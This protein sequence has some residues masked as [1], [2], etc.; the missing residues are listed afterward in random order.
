MFKKRF[1]F[2][3]LAALLC[4]S[5]PEAQEG[6]DLN[7]STETGRGG[8][9][10]DEKN[11]ITKDSPQEERGNKGGDFD[12]FTE[13][14]R[15]GQAIDEKNSI[16]KDSPR[17]GGSDKGWDFNPSTETGRGGQVTDEKNSITKDS[18]REE[19]SD[20]GWDFNPSTETG[21]GGQTGVN[22]S[23][24]SF[25]LPRHEIG[26]MP[27]QNDSIELGFPRFIIWSLVVF[28]FG[29]VFMG[30]VLWGILGFRKPAVQGSQ[31]VSDDHTSAIK[32]VQKKNVVSHEMVEYM[33]K[34]DKL[35]NELHNL[36]QQYRKVGELKEQ[37]VYL[38]AKL[39]PSPLIETRQTKME[40]PETP[41]KN[42]S[43]AALSQYQNWDSYLGQKPKMDMDSGISG[44][45]SS[46]GLS[47]GNQKPRTEVNISEAPYR[48]Q[49]NSYV[50]QPASVPPAPKTQTAA[51]IINAFN[52]WASGNP[53]INKLP[54]L[55][56]YAN[57][58][59][60]LQSSQTGKIDTNNPEAEW[61]VSREPDTDGRRY[62]FPNP[63]ALNLASRLEELYTKSGAYKAKGENRIKVDSPCIMS[64]KGFISG[65]G[66]FTVV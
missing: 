66:S 59:G 52:T 18:P 50:N 31:R 1:A 53:R 4:V 7:P 24:N 22:G 43:G 23:R 26:T 36:E 44:N 21:R 35:C 16:T 40:T 9:A 15:G 3:L 27:I 61:V 5:I 49:G 29:M 38:K 20:K 11:S 51:E 65:K 30:V 6:G 39:P 10:I 46:R 54:F 47:G 28:G 19:G 13:T 45:Q 64:D 8:Q 14:G 17:E 25:E 2:L 41:A 32:S 58:N 60:R 48:G 56:S 42:S 63:A 33:R 12:L 34:I 62:L 37:I 57:H 55:F